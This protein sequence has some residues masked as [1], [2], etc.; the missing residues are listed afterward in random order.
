VDGGH[1]AIK[2]SRIYGIMDK[3][4]GEGT[5]FRIPW[6][7]RAVIYDVRARPR[8]V[9]SLTGSK[10][11]DGRR[12]VYGPGWTRSL[13]LKHFVSQ[14]AMAGRRLANGQH[15]PPCAGQAAY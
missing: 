6:L 3:I 8:N 10:G 2:F 9:A 1:R 7:E 14:P 12:I 13:T 4:Y 11:T 15:H 5:H